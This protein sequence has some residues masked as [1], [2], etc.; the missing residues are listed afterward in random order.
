MC[1][2]RVG[3]AVQSWERRWLSGIREALAVWSEEG[4]AKGGRE[5]LRAGPF[6]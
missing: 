3:H 6:L 1:C 2:A 4:A 5:C